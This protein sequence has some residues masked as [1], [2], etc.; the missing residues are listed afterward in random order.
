MLK[1]PNAMIFGRGGGGGVV[2]R[3]LK[4][5][6]GLPIRE[7]AVQG[8]QFWNKRLTL[9]VGDRLSDSAFVRLNGLFEDSATFRDFVDLRRWG[10]NPTAT[11]L[12]GPETVLTLS[13]EYFHDDR[14][15]D[16]GIPSQFGR[17]YRYRQ[18]ISTFFGN[19][20]L[21][22][23]RVDAHIATAALEHRFESGVQLRSQLRFADYDKFYQVVYPSIRAG[24]AVNAAGTA[25]ELSAFNNETPRTNL[26]SQNDF[27]YKFAT[28]PLA[29][30]VLAGF[31]LGRQEGVTLR[32]D[33]FFATTG[34]QS[35]TVNPLSPVSRV[36]VRF[37]NIASGI[38]NR[39]DLG[40]AAAYVQDQIEIGPH[41]QLIGGVR[42]D[43]FDFAS[44]DRRNQVGS[45]RIDDLISPRAGIVLKPFE[46]LAFYGNYSVS[47]LPS[48]G[49]QF[50]ALSPGLAIAEPERFEN[51][52]F[53]V[54]WDVSPA[55]QLTGAFYDLDRFNQRLSDPNRPGFFLSTGQTNAKGIEIGANGFVTD[56]WQ[57]AGGYAF[58]DARVV[59]GFS[60]GATVIR[61]G[62]QVGLVPF[63]S[64]TL[65]NRFSVTPEFGI[66]VGAIYQTHTF[67]SVDNTVRLPGY[68]RFDLGLFYQ[69]SEG[70]R[71]QVNI[72]NL[73]DRAYIATADSNTNIS[74][75]APRTVRVQV[76]ARF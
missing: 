16:R 17:P 37:R 20:D 21:S 23:A 71:A 73:F 30:T 9:D 12:L 2:N 72:E 48:A 1:G 53:G 50:S 68:A 36:P 42:Y 43:H 27:T 60:S 51:R 39:Y 67:A 57:V 28:G 64:I 35:I 65:W 8:G 10:I 15:A 41:L 55:L 26:F 22:L 6:N 32:E 59:S 56:W 19:P 24:G 63:D 38:N 5:A 58:T 34:T 52:E 70:V 54:K 33:G 66:G 62:S 61:P 11:F 4:E 45:R 47:Y 76:I 75:G 18:T 49:D 7:V 13:Y 40:L 44:T 31:E 69:V 74:P 25:V 14:T 29:H 46:T 3:V